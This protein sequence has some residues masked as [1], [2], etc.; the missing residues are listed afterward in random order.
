MTNWRLALTGLGIRV[1]GMVCNDAVEVANNDLM[2]VFRDRCG[3]EYAGH[4]MD[5]IHACASGSTRLA[6]LADWIPAHVYLPTSGFWTAW[7]G[8]SLRVSPGDVLIAVGTL[9]LITAAGKV[10][11]GWT[12]KLIHK[13]RSN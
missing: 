13:L 7:D 5:F 11:K 3:G 6:G 2:P 1:L 10:L 4:Q 9:I 8:W 12:Q